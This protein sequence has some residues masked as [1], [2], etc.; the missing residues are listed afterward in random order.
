MWWRRRPE[1]E[2]GVPAPKVNGFRVD[3]AL[4][5]GIVVLAILLPVF[6]AS[7]VIVAATDRWLFGR[8]KAQP[9]PA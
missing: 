4:A 7:L 2:L 5:I 6:G 8:V 9:T 1:G 3:R